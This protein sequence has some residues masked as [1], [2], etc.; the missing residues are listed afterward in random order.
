M[1]NVSSRRERD[2]KNTSLELQNARQFL[3]LQ[4]DFNLSEE[5]L[6]F[7]IEEINTRQRRFEYLIREKKLISV[8][9]G[10]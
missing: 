5:E 7:L 2:L 8:E 4:K 6:Q 1:K 3:E 10:E 9:E